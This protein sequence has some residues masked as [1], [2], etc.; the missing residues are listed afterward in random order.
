M[1][2]EIDKKGS[3]WNKE[4]REAKEKDF[5]VKAQSLQ[6]QFVDY[7]DELNKK[8]CRGKTA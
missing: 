2:D 8:K 3:V 7:S 5:Q 4:T 1:K 6:K